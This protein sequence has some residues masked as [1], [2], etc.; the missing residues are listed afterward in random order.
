M[1]VILFPIYLDLKDK[2]CLLVGGGQV[3]ERKIENL[4]DYGL[5]MRVVS[6]EATRRIQEW[7]QQGIVNWQLR[8]F[9]EEDLSGVFIA[10]VAT[11]NNNVNHSV[12][13]ACRKAGVL[14]NA[15]DDPPNCDFYVPSIIRRGSLVLAI[16]TEGKSP[17]FARRLREELE[18]TITPEYGEFVDMLGDIREEIKEKVPDISMRKEVFASL[19]YSEILDLLQAGE[20]EKARERI[21]ACMSSWRD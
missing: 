13:K 19:V 2:T 5:N 17:Y 16:S 20:K 7:A 10:F 15:V 9:N 3:A 8:D 6:P 1:R 12:V 21:E 18:I 14:V 11:D 4:L